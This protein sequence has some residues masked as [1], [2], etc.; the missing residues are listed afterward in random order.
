MTMKIK[1]DTER[2]KTASAAAMAEIQGTSNV[3]NTI[4]GIVY[5]SHNYWEGDGQREYCQA[6]DSKSENISNI[7]RRYRDNAN[8]LMQMA[9]NYDVTEKAA[10]EEAQS[11][12]VDVII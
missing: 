11:L 10:V 7:I 1:V 12:P 9:D 2:L 6:F 3:F 5:H 4:R 8:E